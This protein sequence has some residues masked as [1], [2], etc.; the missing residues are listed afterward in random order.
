M[1]CPVDLIAICLPAS[2]VYLVSSG[3]LT[4]F[5]ATGSA[6]V[7]WS[8]VVQQAWE[9]DVLHALRV[10]VGISRGRIV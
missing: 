1:G 9:Q 8:V 6:K 10:V 2:G 3:T 4:H 7:V 5:W